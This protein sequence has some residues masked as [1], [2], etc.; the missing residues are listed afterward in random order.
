[1]PY[2]Q[3]LC[4]QMED[5]EAGIVTERNKGVDE[6]LFNIVA[7]YLNNRILLHETQNDLKKYRITAGVPQGSVLG[8]LLWNE[9]YDGLLNINLHEGAKLVGYADDIALVIHQPTA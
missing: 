4:R 5:T 2:E 1:M 6:Y 8:S 7:D 3:D 9:M